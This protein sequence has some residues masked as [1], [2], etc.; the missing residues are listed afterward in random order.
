MIQNA[1]FLRILFWMLLLGSF[2]ACSKSD[3]ADMAAYSAKT[4]DGSDDSGIDDSG[5]TTGDDS[6]TDGTDDD[7]GEGD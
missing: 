1:N 6:G 4:G 2:T 5:D 3:L 7:D